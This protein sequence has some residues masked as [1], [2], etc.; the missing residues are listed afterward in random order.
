VLLALFLTLLWLTTFVLKC[1]KRK[2]FLEA[3]VAEQQMIL[4]MYFELRAATLL[5][6]EHNKSERSSTGK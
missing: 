6:I 1:M 3:H 4:C 5:F 2:T